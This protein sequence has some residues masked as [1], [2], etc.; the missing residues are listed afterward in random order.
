MRPT[1][2]LFIFMSNPGYIC[3]AP[4][5][6]STE[7]LGYIRTA[8]SCLSTVTLGY[9]CTKPWVIYAQKPWVTRA[10]APYEQ[11]TQRLEESFKR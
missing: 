4:N 5:C 1:I 10:H 9:I 11:Q 8:P 7:T 6:L 3:T 2:S